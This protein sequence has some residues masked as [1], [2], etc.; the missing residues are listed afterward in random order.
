MCIVCY[1]IM[2][3]LSY[4]NI[5]SCVPQNDTGQYVAYNVVLM[6]VHVDCS[7]EA[8]EVLRTA[9]SEVTLRVCRPPAG[10]GLCS[11]APEES[12]PPLAPPRHRGQAP[13]PPLKHRIATAPRATPASDFEDEDESPASLLRPAS[14]ADHSVGVSTVQPPLTN[15]ECN[16]E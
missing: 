4:Q 5:T 9:P 11:V 15:V 10:T 8:L 3:I 16:S 13:L 12:E 2:K 6:L 7:Q 1:H 14:S